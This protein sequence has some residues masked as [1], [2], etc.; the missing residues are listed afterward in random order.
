MM[1]IFFQITSNVAL[2]QASESYLHIFVRVKKTAR[3]RSSLH[4]KRKILSK[5]FIRTQSAQFL[6]VAIVA[7]PNTCF[8]QQNFLQFW[9]KL[10]LFLQDTNWLFFLFPA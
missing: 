5:H 2:K 1:N 9:Q 8:P 10:D 7:L 4:R 6:H 3:W